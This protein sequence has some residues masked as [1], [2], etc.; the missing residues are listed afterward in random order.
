[1]GAPFKLVDAGGFEPPSKAFRIPA[2][3]ACRLFRSGADPRVKAS[4]APTSTISGM[5]P[6]SALS[7]FLKSRGQLAPLP[8]SVA[9]PSAPRR[10]LGRQA[11]ARSLAAEVN[12]YNIAVVAYR[13]PA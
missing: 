13:L 7:Q 9:R 2:L 6:R 10:F 5:R 8:D 12:A 4:K 11:L 3:R 1:M